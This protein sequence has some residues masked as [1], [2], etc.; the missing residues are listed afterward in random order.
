[1]AL[2]SISATN[3]ART[4][5]S[6]VC[7][8][9]W[10]S[11]VANLHIWQEMAHSLNTPHSVR[12]CHKVIQVIYRI[13]CYSILLSVLFLPL[14][15]KVRRN[16]FGRYICAW[17]HTTLCDFSALYMYVCEVVLCIC[18]MIYICQTNSSGCNW[19][20]ISIVRAH[21]LENNLILVANKLLQ[22]HDDKIIFRTLNKQTYDNTQNIDITFLLMQLQA[23]VFKTSPKANGC[24]V[25]YY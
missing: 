8:R 25:T 19:Q 15:W 4:V 3:D 14:Y 21:Y 6:D 20:C 12:P 18:T 11:V 7:P 2:I 9:A 16:D 1:M 23:G 5:D 24:Y 10:T 13:R 22:I 17:W